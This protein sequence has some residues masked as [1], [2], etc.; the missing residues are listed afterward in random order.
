M[1]AND[2]TLI[3]TAAGSSSRFGKNKLFL[4]LQ[5]VPLILKTLA[6]FVTVPFQNVI[7]TYRAEDK[8]QMQHVL[9]T[10]NS[11]WPMQLIQG[12]KTRRDSVENAVNKTSSKYVMIH[13]GARPFVSELLIK[14]IIDQG[15]LYKAVIPGLQMTDTIKWVEHNQVIKTVDRNFLFRIQTPQ[16]FAKDML[17]NAYKT[18]RVEATDEA[19]ILE[20]AGIKITVVDGDVENIKVTFPEDL[21]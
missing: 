21:R 8:A 6:C 14:R 16:F 18:S 12:G 2:I 19:M 3:I 1:T 4:D 10:F 5:G 11:P 9:S 20:E 13:D 17:L 7:V 15:R